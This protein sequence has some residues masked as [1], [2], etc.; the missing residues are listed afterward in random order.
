VTFVFP[1]IVYFVHLVAA[2]LWPCVVFFIFWLS[3]LPWE[4]PTFQ[5]TL[6]VYQ[7]TLSQT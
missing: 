2:L 4:F 3:R 7:C 6:P 1:G 5:K